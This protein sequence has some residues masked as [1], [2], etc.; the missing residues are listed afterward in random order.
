MNAAG[1]C[2]AHPR[3]STFKSGMLVIRNP[4]ILFLMNKLLTYHWQPLRVFYKRGR[5]DYAQSW[6]YYSAEA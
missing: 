2:R 1:I 6:S 5:F 4:M 3:I